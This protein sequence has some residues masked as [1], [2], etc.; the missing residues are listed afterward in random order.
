MMMIELSTDSCQIRIASSYL[1]LG[2][3]KIVVVLRSSARQEY[4]PNTN[5]SSFATIS[6]EVKYQQGKLRAAEYV[7]R[8]TSW[9]TILENLIATPVGI[10]GGHCITLHRSLKSWMAYLNRA[11]GQ[12]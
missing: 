11:P 10:A 4:S 3:H 9:G 12:G 2:A 6:K 1:I 7:W 8:A 5:L